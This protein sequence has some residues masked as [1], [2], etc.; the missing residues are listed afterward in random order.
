MPSSVNFQ[1]NK[2]NK[3]YKTL[4]TETSLTVLVTVSPRIQDDSNLG[5]FIT[6]EF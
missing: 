3:N 2:S 4:L 6:V 1:Q 5:V